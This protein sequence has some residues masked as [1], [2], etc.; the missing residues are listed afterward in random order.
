MDKTKVFDPK[1]LLGKKGIGL[2]LAII[3]IIA[4]TLLPDSDSLSHQGIMG[5]TLLLAAIVLW[6]CN[7]LPVGV[8][9]ILTLVLAA[10][11]GVTEFQGAFS[12]FGNPVFIYVIAI[13]A[14]PI[15]VLKTNWGLRIIAYLVKRTGT[16]SNLLVLAFMIVTGLLSTVMADI[17][18]MV[19]MLGLAYVVMSSIDAKPGESR[20]GKAL[21]IGIPV[22]S[23]TGGIATPA[24]STFNVMAMGILQQATG[25]TI[26][27][28]DW[29]IVGLPLVIV[30]LPI[31]WL[32]IVKILKPEPIGSETIDALKNEAVKVGKPTPFEKAVILFF[33][34]VLALW[35]A[36]NWIPVL[37]VANVAVIFLALLMLPGI[38][39]IT[40]KDLQNSVPW[41]VLLMLGSILSLG[42]I[43]TATGGAKFLADLFVASGIMS[44]NFFLMILITCALVYILHTVFPVGPAILGLFLPVLIGIC[45]SFGISPAV[46][47]I[48]M[49]LIVAGNYLLPV[50][51]TVM[52]SYND[53]YFSFGDMLKTGILPAIAL[54]VLMA[55]WVP[56]IVGVMGF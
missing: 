7:S 38:N 28:L 53:G 10:L 2:A 30:L 14:L 32:S 22:A 41:N 23:V 13:F 15:I 45:A 54:I 48:T 5:L 17:P 46:P 11:L 21:F 50:N 31:C 1:E 47:T 33:I 44:L 24:G 8:T 4:G 56:F 12:G 18:A 3:V 39:A 25:T 9:G 26:S 37:S 40:W 27:F 20:L 19:S 35:I 36:G 52:I 43:I 51:P 29:T 42:S 55:L 49:A 6:F 34:L 16:S